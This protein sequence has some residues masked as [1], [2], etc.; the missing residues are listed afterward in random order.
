MQDKYR[1]NLIKLAEHLEKKPGL[2]RRYRIRFGM[3][4]WA[5]KK[6]RREF[7][8]ERMGPVELIR[9]AQ[10]F[11]GGCGTV[12]CAMGEAALLFPNAALAK[13]SFCDLGEHL[14]GVDC[15][16]S[17]PDFN[18]LFGSQ[19]VHTDNT[20]SGAAKRIR[21]FLEHGTPKNWEGQMRGQEPLCY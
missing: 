7:E 20:R 6:R 21:Y 15:S 19:W 13:D 3:D 16:Y 1:D 12:V 9:L 18:W 17:S 5:I 2:L 10:G 4:N 8:D 14:F 11:T